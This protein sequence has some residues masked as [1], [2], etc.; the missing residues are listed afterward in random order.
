VNGRF[1]VRYGA[2]GGSGRILWQHTPTGDD[3]NI[4]SPVGQ[5]IAR[6]VRENGLY[7]LTTNTNVKETA[8]DPDALTE[9][10][11][12]W[13]LPLA[14]LPYWLRGREQPNVPA[15]RKVAADA[16]LAQLEQAGWTIEYQSYHATN[17]LPER[18]RITREKLDLRL[19]LEE[20][21]PPQ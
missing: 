7:T 15:Q 10:V 4:L 8:A 5:G 21:T 16:R 19:I 3:L 20:W 14:G 17:G 11:L 9:R 13:R 12:G 1:A 2:E 6:I 18:L